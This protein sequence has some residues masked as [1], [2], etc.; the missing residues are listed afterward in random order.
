[1]APVSTKNFKLNFAEIRRIGVRFPNR[2]AA[3]F[4]AFRFVRQL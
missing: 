4:S 2:I 1:M 3:G